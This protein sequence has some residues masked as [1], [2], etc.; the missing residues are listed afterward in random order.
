MKLHGRACICYNFKGHRKA[1]RLADSGVR[2]DLRDN[3]DGLLYVVFSCCMFFTS[4]LSTFT[5]K[6][7]HYHVRQGVPKSARGKDVWWKPQS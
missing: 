1:A 7:M 4:S 2:H 5:S 3:D 6:T